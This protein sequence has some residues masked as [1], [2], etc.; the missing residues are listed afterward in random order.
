MKNHCNF[1]KIV[2]FDKKNIIQE[3][4]KSVF[5]KSFKKA[6]FLLLIEPNSL[7]MRSHVRARFGSLFQDF[8]YNKI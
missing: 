4:N 8:F 5:K 3:I 1:F 7:W 6:F 2:L